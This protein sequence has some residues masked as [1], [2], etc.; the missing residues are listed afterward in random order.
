MFELKRDGA[1]VTDRFNILRNEV[2][3]LC[4]TEVCEIWEV[5]IGPTGDSVGV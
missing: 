3:D 5:E 2:C 4:T 1:N